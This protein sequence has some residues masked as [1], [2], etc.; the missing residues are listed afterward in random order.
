MIKKKI[1]N[2][3]DVYGTSYFDGI[4]FPNIIWCFDLISKVKNK[5]EVEKT[6]GWT[7]LSDALS[8]VNRMRF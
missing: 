6:V 2:W 8:T 7:V 3:N 4:E 5:V 1:Y